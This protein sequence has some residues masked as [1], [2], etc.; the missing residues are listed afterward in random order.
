[1]AH[2]LIFS[3]TIF[4]AVFGSGFQRL[5]FHF[6]WVLELSPA[7]TT[8]TLNWLNACRNSLDSSSDYRLGFYNDSWPSLYRLCTDHTQNT[9]SN[10]LY[11][12]AS[13]SFIMDRVEKP[14]PTAL[15][16]LRA[17][18][19]RPL[20]THGCCLQSNYLATAIIYLLISRLLPD[21]RSS[22]LQDKCSK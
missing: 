10:S 16:L 22:E 14:F 2:R 12:V 18:L 15:L 4:T 20:A 8:E 19:L 17:Y 9:V 21:N 6:I 7:S 13:R 3:V 5:T 11:I 1:M